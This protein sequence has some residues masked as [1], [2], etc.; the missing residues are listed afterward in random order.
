M[1]ATVCMELANRNESHLIKFAHS[2]IPAVSNH[3][4]SRTKENSS[5]VEWPNAPGHICAIRVH[6][7]DPDNQ[8]ND[9]NIFPA[10]IDDAL[11]KKFP[12][13]FVSTREFCQFK[14][15]AC[16]YADKLKKNG[17]LLEEIYI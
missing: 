17:K 14:R 7:T 12:L 4:Y 6:C 3:W 10:L 8:K 1:V 2:D 5:Y 16:E 13:T 11:V 15:D 9:P